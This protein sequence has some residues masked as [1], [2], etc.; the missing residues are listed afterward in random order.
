VSDLAP[1]RA[2]AAQA[3]RDRLVD[4]AIER[5]ARDGLLARFDAVA[6]DAGVTK[7]ALYHHFGSKDGLVAA[8]YKEA[9]NRH[10]ERVL[11]AEDAGAGR[12]TG[13]QRLL[14]LV[15]ESARLYTSG[16]PFYVLLQTLHDAART[17]RPELEPIARRVQ[18]R[19]REHMVQLVRAGQRDGSIRADRDPEA[20]GLTVNAALQ[21]FLSQ[22][23]E[24]AAQRRR[25]VRKFRDLLED[26]L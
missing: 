26:V 25:W 2:A 17:S 8:V 21:G 20:V 5:F 18:A 12:H 3:T 23:S 10:A 7:G 6:A 9:I 24:P 16:T 4:A 14:R 1:T 22:L 11:D 15:D 13:R 19:Q